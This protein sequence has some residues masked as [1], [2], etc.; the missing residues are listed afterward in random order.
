MPRLPAIPSPFDVR[1]E[2]SGAHVTVFLKGRAD[3]V[4]IDEL[5][6]VLARVAIRQPQRLV[7]DLSQLETLWSL[8]LGEMVG[9]ARAVQRSG[10]TVA[11]AGATG[12]VRNVLL[13]CRMDQ[14][15]EGLDG[16]AEE[17]ASNSPSLN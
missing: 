13:T 12:L 5:K 10:G 6:A 9:C 8:V 7:F 17:S 16:D 1:S 14:M 11:I 3:V 15:F 4:S 2:V